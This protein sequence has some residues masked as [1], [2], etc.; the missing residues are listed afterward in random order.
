MAFENPWLLWGMLLAGI[1]VVIHLIHRQ[2]A[3]PL[4][5]AALEYLLLSDKRLARHLRL[6]QLLVLLLRMALIAALAF[7]LSKPYMVPDGGAAPDLGHPGAVVLVLDD[8]MSTGALLPDGRTLLEHTVDQATRA[9]DRGGPR[10]RFAIVAAGQPARLLTAGLVL[11]PDRVKQILGSLRP[12]VRGGDMAGA[13]REAERVLATSSEPRRRVLLFGDHAAHAWSGVSQPWALAEPPQADLI[14]TP[15]GAPAENA[16]VT[17]VTVEP[18][19]DGLRGEMWVRVRVANHG[20]DPIQTTV[21]VDMGDKVVVQSLGVPAEGSEE[22]VLSL[23]L[24]ANTSSSSG[25]A[26]IAPDALEADDTW[27]FAVDLGDAVQVAVVNGA[28]RNVT[29]LD[30]VFFLRA[31]LHATGAEG[32]PLHAHHLALDQLNPERLGSMDVVVLA[33]VAALSR[34]Q[35]AALRAFVSGGGG[36]LVA[37]GDQMTEATNR[38]FGDLLPLPIRSVKQVARRGEADEALTALRLTGVDFS[39]PALEGFK[40]IEDASLFRAR[41]YAHVLLES[42]LRPQTRVLASF[43]GGSPALVEAPLGS[44]RTMMWTTSLDRDWSDLVIRSSFVP[45]LHQSVLYLA[46]RLQEDDAPMRTVGHPV[47]IQAP[48]G[49]GDLLLQRP[50]GSEVRVVGPADGRDQTVVIEDTDL[51]GLYVLSRRSSPAAPVTFAVHGDRTESDLTPYGRE[52]ASALLSRPGRDAAPTLS[53]EATPAGLASP[54]TGRT[55]LWP[56]VLMAL[57]GL[58]ALETVL[59]LRRPAAG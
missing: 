15:D 37:A 46:G 50:D 56:F 10:T 23:A 53:A 16:A 42:T 13:L 52:Q 5:F 14:E 26:S 49:R 4:P 18:A 34:A 48:P 57:F 29:F 59:I 51:A 32:T 9:V 40:H 41:T 36:L 44:G 3:R 11:D 2:Q 12:S 25:S 54:P 17:G 45:L 30:E 33:N 47:H 35:A 39:H 24:P 55:R 43:T 58:L 21:R 20:S 27:W 38:S 19:P 31:G 22:A 7:A 6:K 8:S 28:P 1:P